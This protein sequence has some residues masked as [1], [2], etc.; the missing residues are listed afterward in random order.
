[1]LREMG[2]GAATLSRD[3]STPLQIGT[4][5][6]EAERQIESDAFTMANGKRLQLYERGDT[7]TFA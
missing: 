1:M 4:A 5:A 6:S 7:H 2:G 3:S